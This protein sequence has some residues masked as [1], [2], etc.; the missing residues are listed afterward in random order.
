MVYISL[1]LA[2][3][4]KHQIDTHKHK[5]E[6]LFFDWLMTSFNSVLD[7]LGCRDITDILHINNIICDP[8]KPVMDNNAN[9][10]IKSLD[11]CVSIHDLPIKYTNDDII[12]FINKYTRR[13]NRIIEYIKSDSKI[14]FIRTGNISNEEIDAFNK[15]ILNINPKCN[16]A[17]IIIDVSADNNQNTIIKY[18][19]CLILKKIYSPPTISDWTTSFYNW[20]QIFVD[21]EAN[22]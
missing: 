6:T 17:L 12:E 16:Y 15:I 22:I 13:F 3:N 10:I 1:G 18:E 19:N 4:V 5:I 8:N 9:I 20:K 7:I 14:Y 21:I 2:C 11:F